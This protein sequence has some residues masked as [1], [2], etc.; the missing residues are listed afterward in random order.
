MVEDDIWTEDNE[1]QYWSEIVNNI[2]NMI[3]TRQTFELTVLL[4][5]SEKIKKLNN[6]F[7][8]INQVTN[9]LSFPNFSPKQISIGYK[10]YLGDIAIAYDKVKT[11]SENS[12]ISF[13]DHFSHL[14]VHSILHLLGFDHIDNN[15][16][17]VMEIIEAAVLRRLGI[18]NP[19]RI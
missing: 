8:G 18:K 12:G 4:T 11:E 13:I 15:D 9:V 1:A 19:Y 16:A 17:D 3:Y 2:S 10:G 5:N 14:I 7:R 6:D